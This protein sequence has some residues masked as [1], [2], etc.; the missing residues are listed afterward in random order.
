VRRPNREW[1]GRLAGEQ[2]VAAQHFR[3]CEQPRAAG[4][5]SEEIAAGIRQ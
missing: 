3:E 4:G 1:V 5:G 2:T